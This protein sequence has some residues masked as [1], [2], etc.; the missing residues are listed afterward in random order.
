MQAQLLHRKKQRQKRLNLL[1][2][3]LQ[4]ERRLHRVKLPQP[5]QTAATTGG[6]SEAMYGDVN[7]DGKVD[8]TDAIIL[9]KYQAGLVTFTDAQKANAN[10][11]ITDGTEKHY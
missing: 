2:L 1:P 10:C 9:N 4:K 7:M 5:L 6:E 3:L 11:D 8:L